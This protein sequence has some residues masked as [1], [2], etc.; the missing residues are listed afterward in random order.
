MKIDKEK[1]PQDEIERLIMKYSSINS[2]FWDDIEEKIGLL[3]HSYN[4]QA[5]IDKAISSEKHKLITEVISDLKSLLKDYK[6]TKE[7]IKKELE[8][9]EFLNDDEKSKEPLPKWAK[10]EVQNRIKEL[11]GENGV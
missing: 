9:L 2:G 3:S 4:I 10:F 1:I 7:E 8:L 5:E 11:K 6:T